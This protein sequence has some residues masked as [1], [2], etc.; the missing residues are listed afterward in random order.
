MILDYM[1]VQLVQEMHL[2]GKPHDKSEIC[3]LLGYYASYSGNSLLTIWD[4][5]VVPLLRVKISKK[6]AS[7]TLVCI[8]KCVGDD[9]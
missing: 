6:K 2:A 4:K 8:G 3:A 1:C 7:H 5:L 9:W